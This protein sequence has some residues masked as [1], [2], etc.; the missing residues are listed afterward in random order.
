MPQEWL[1][2]K[3]DDQAAG[4]NIPA[5]DG[6]GDLQR[7]RVVLKPELA[8]HF[9]RLVSHAQ[10]Q[11]HGIE[12]RETDQVPQNAKAVANHVESVTLQ[13]AL[14]KGKL[15]L[16]SV[17]RVF[18]AEDC[19]ARLICGKGTDSLRR[20]GSGNGPAREGWPSGLRRTPGK[21]VGV[22]APPGFE[23]PSLRHILR[24]LNTHLLAISVQITVFA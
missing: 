22:K 7:A 15:T 1:A 12:R 18:R 21:R 19:L 24:K 10:I 6:L 5:D 20:T 2:S 14:F 3:G 23:S 11:P 16:L 13:K 17:N 9:A 4:I 8:K